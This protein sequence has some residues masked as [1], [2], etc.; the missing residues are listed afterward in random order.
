MNL[1]TKIPVLCIDL[2]T[3]IVSLSNIRL[4]FINIFLSNIS[5]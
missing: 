4:A 3:C 2:V 1:K 5:N